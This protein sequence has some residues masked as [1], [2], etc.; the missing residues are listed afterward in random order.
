MGPIKRNHKVRQIILA[1][2]LVLSCILTAAAVWL[3]R[4]G[5]GASQ[6][7]GDAYYEGRFPLE[8]YFDYTQGDD[9]WAGNS[10]G[11]ARDT[12]ASSGCLTCCI[13][14]SLK[15]Q[16]IYDYTPGELNRIF[17]EN[18]VY[19]ENGAILWAALEEALPG[20]YADLSDDTSAASI[21]CMIRDGRY[22]IVKVRRKSGAVHWIM[23][24][25]T[26]KEDFDITAMD[27]IDGYVHLSDYS[28]LI[29]GVRVVS[30]KRGAGQVFV[31]EDGDSGGDSGDNPAGN[32]KNGSYSNP[33]SD[34]GRCPDR[35]TADSAAAH[36]AIHPEGTCLE[37]RFP[38][39]AG[40]TREA[41]PEG[42]FQQ[43]LR[44][45]P[46]KADKSPVLL[47][48]GSEKG[49]QGAHEAVF[50]LPVF[51]SDLQQC[52]DS[53]IRIYAEYFW[54]T[55]NQDRI[56][57]HLTNGFLM[58]YPSW[59]EGNRLQVDGNQVSW[60]KKASY[61]DSYETFL[62]Y[63]EYVMMYAGTLSLNEESTPI[64]PD[65]LKAG[66]MFI[67]GGSPGHCVMVADVAVDGNGDACFL[68]AQGYMPAQ[69]F[70][71]LKNPASPGNPWYDTRDLSYPFYTPEYVFQEGSLKRWGGF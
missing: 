35:I 65:Q 22:P 3:T 57:F 25:G 49:N 34:P 32:L 66:D 27:P 55:G 17:N 16:G 70:H 51:D 39:P 48:D 26:E 8:A 44:R 64:S 37:E 52:A 21:N 50:D 46:L 41:A 1:G 54:S 6:V 71:I 56:A 67:K 69:E 53:I 29:Y 38:T 12:M 20:V 5:K 10:L 19:N 36:T 4:K 14:A 13:A 43:Y 33:D 11:S 63:L 15:A 31:G 58:D 68:L 23:L 18:G 60:V 42:S 61:D 28:D 45:Y 7:T 59:R 24:T 62:L 30:A 47:Y 2:I 40:Y 9:D